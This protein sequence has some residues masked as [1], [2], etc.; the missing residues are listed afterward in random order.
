MTRNSRYYADWYVEA[1]R[2]LE[3]AEVALPKEYL[4][5]A[6]VHIHQAVEKALK[7][8]IIQNGEKPPRTHDL[9]RLV[10]LAA[11][12]RGELRDQRKWLEDVSDYYVS[13][14]YPGAHSRRG[15]TGE[16]HSRGETPL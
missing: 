13:F 5:I 12:Y 16:R 3:M 4:Q 9:V 11:A 2:E 14:H 8:F 15:E 7:G 1:P 10:D 6:A